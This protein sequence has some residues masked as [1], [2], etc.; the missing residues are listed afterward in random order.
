MG[1]AV[2]KGIL[3]KGEESISIK[4]AQHAERDTTVCFAYVHPEYS[5]VPSCDEAEKSRSYAVGAAHTGIIPY[6][7]VFTATARTA[8]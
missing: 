6:G 1:F 2:V 3:A 4:C 5:E 8:A 7:I